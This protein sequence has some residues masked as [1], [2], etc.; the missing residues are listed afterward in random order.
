MSSAV[1]WPISVCINC[2]CSLWVQQWSNGRSA[3]GE[4]SSSCDT[5][6][7]FVL[8]DFQRAYDAK[9]FLGHPFKWCDSAKFQLKLHP[10]KTRLLRFGR[11]AADQRKGKGGIRLHTRDA[12]ILLGLTHCCGRSKSGLFLLLTPSVRYVRG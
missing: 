10:N 9:R 7:D 6:D 11:F 12:S 8:S 1:C 4:A 5:A 3:L 2:A